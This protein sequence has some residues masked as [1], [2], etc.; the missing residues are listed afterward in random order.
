MDGVVDQLRAAAL[1]APDQLRAASEAAVHWLQSHLGSSPPPSTFESLAST[2][3]DALPGAAQHT[4]HALPFAGVLT[5]TTLY[6]AIAIIALALIPLGF[7]PLERLT[8]VVPSRLDPF[9][10]LHDIARAA[11]FGKAGINMGIMK[12]RNRRSGYYLFDSAAKRQGDKAMIKFESKTWTWRQMHKNSNRL[13][14]YWQEQGLKRGDVVAMVVPNKPTF[15]EIWLSFMAIGVTPAFINY[16]L[17]GDALKHCIDVSKASR[18]L[19]DTDYVENVQKIELDKEIKRYIWSDDM[20]KGEKPKEAKEFT[21]ITADTYAKQSDE[22]IPDKA[23]AEIAWKDPIC[24]IYT[25]GTSGLPKAAPC[26][27]A[28]FVTAGMAYA[29]YCDFRSDDILY[30]PLPLYHSSAAFLCFGSLLHSGVTMALSRKFSASKFFDEVREGNASVIQYI[31]EIARYLMNTKESDGDKNHRVRMAYGNGMPPDVWMNFKKRF[32]IPVVNEFY[33]ATESPTFLFNYHS[34]FSNFGSC[35][36]GRESPFGRAVI[37]NV[38]VKVDPDT[39]E[40]VRNKKGYC[41]PAAYNE[42]GELFVKMDDLHGLVPAK[43]FQGYKGNK[44]STSDKVA[45]DVFKKGDSWF[46]TGDLLSL[47]AAGYYKFCDRLGDTFRWKGE[48]VATTEVQGAMNKFD[49]I[50]EVAVFGVKLPKH[51]GRAGCAALEAKVLEK[52]DLD[53]LA[54]H[55]GDSLPKYAQPLFLRGVTEIETTST[56]KIV[57]TNLKKQGVDPEE[58][59][60]DKVMVLDKGKYRPFEKSDWEKIESGDLKY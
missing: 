19:V 34:G 3:K 59:G 45:Q 54:K 37:G 9:G 56:N 31:G 10:I 7:A 2:V 12:S 4:S 36:I 13:A 5:L 35:S 57:T 40:V 16:N 55:L 32:N 22:R 23:R 44:K 8:R 41:V 49:G 30:T 43:S 58:T 11:A 14:H 21:V 28:K 1:A 52:L 25:S 60:E 38:I 47:S 24:F 17:Q 50:E 26:S 51:D 18:I 29:N 42:P 27:Q 48:N 39:Q 46:R 53:K 33:A 15:I 20:S 6:W